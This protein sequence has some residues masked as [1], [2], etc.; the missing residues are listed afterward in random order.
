MMHTSS[1]CCCDSRACAGAACSELRDSCDR[2]R[3]IVGLP[4]GMAVAAAPHVDSRGS[5]PSL[6]SITP[7]E[8]IWKL[9][10]P[11]R[12][13]PKATP[14]VLPSMHEL[15]GIARHLAT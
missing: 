10:T 2:R 6:P 11:P 7:V 8:L 5:D 4:A 3:G 1:A 9:P 15:A 12:R 13:T 14:L